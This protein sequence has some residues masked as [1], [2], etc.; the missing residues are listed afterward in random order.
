[1][2]PGASC[3]LYCHVLSLRAR[4]YFQLSVNR[5]QMNLS[6]I[7]GKDVIMQ[8]LILNKNTQ[9]LENVFGKELLYS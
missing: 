5:V 3:E 2:C 1:M 8:S 7:S 6:I 4:L 9:V